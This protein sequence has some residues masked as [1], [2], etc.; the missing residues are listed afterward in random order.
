[1]TVNIFLL[2]ILQLL[3]MDSC[4]QSTLSTLFTAVCFFVFAKVV[5]WFVE[6]WKQINYGIEI[7]GLTLTVAYSGYFIVFGIPYIQ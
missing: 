1:M 3:T 2:F 4:L 5:R 7:H 6:M